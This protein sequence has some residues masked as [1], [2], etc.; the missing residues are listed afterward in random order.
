M[1]ETAQRYLSTAEVVA[2][3][4]ERGLKHVTENTVKVAAYYKNKPLQRTLVAGRV[5]FTV[6]AVEK[7]LAGVQPT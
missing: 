5:Y 6:E 7:W 1:N 3:A 4:R 2:I